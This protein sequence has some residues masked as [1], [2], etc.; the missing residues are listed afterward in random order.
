MHYSTHGNLGSGFLEAVDGGIEAAFLG[1]YDLFAPTEQGGG[2]FATRQNQGEAAQCGLGSLRGG[3]ARIGRGAGQ[4]GHDGGTLRPG[5]FAA[6]A[7]GSS[8]ISGFENGGLIGRRQGFVDHGLHLRRGLRD[9]ESGT[10][11]P[12]AARDEQWSL[13]FPRYTPRGYAEGGADVQFRRKVLKYLEIIKL[14]VRV[15]DQGFISFAAEKAGGKKMN[16]DAAKGLPAAIVRRMKRR[17]ARGRLFG[18]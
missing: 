10:T 6:R 13:L 7:E 4:N 18:F 16:V 15:T 11:T 1:R 12:N 9:P 14:N 5:E 3:G 17:Y 8:Q 2:G